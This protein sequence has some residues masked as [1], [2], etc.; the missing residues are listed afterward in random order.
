VRRPGNPG[1]RTFARG[2]GFAAPT[3]PPASSSP[4]RPSTKAC[5]KEPRL[6]MADFNIAGNDDLQP[7]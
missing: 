1:R 2:D 3:M 5:A 6:A 7:R 4:C